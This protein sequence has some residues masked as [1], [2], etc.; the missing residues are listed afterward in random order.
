VNRR[1]SRFMMVLVVLIFSTAMIPFSLAERAKRPMTVHKLEELGLEIWTEGEP[2]WE[3][4]LLHYGKKAVFTA[5][6]PV[7]Y[8]PPAA[9]S[10]ASFPGMEVD[11]Q[12]LQEVALSAI[13]QSGRN[14]QLSAES[15][16]QIAPVAVTYS[17]LTG[18]EA[19]FSGRAHEE[20][21]DVKVFVGH[22]PGKGPVV[23]QGYTLKGKLPHISEQ[24][25]R[26]WENVTYLPGPEQVSASPE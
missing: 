26:A 3:T 4:E 21:V 24:I 10:Y 2:E 17:E 20:D 22:K 16:E 1:A 19:T 11:S 7:L 15:V 13:Q 8:Y 12:E 6:S 9:M 25:R 5:Q 23:M 14:Y 18:Y